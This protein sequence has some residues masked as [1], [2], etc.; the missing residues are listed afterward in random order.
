MQSCR[1][2]ESES[3]GVRRDH[4]MRRDHLCPPRPRPD[5]VLPSSDTPCIRSPAAAV[6]RRRAAAGGYT[7][8]SNLRWNTCRT[9]RVACVILNAYLPPTLCAD[10]DTDHHLGFWGVP[11][12]DHNGL[13]GEMGKGEGG[14]G[15]QSKRP[16]APKGVSVHASV[17]IANKH[18]KQAR[19]INPGL[20]PRSRI[21]PVP[22][23]TLGGRGFPPGNRNTLRPSET[24]ARAFAPTPAQPVGI[25][26]R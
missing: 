24:P 13:R 10:L 17:R 4:A 6:R 9:R 7:H 25:H 12:Y 5:W 16:P 1:A 23:S 18:S 22:P 11:V 21:H 20:A 19:Q 8:I 26:A 3:E 14:I 15:N 2:S